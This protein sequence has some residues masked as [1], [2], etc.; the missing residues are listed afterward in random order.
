MLRKRFLEIKNDGYSSIYCVS[1]PYIRPSQKLPE[2]PIMGYIYQNLSMRYFCRIFFYLLTG[3]LL[4]AKTNSSAQSSAKD[5]SMRI[6]AIHNTAREYQRFIATAAPLYSGPQYVEYY[7]LITIGHPFFLNNN[8]NTGSV[9]FDHILYENVKLKYDILENKIVLKDP[10]GLFAV[11]P[12]YDKIDHFTV[13]NHLFSKLE[14]ETINNSLPKSGF[15]E[16]LFTGTNLVLYKKE[17]KI[18]MEDLN[19]KA[20][21]R[22]YI[23]PTINYYLKKGNAYYLFN[24]QKHVLD[25]L[26]DR[27]TELRQYIRKTNP[28]FSNDA[29]N[30][31]LS[32]LNYY[33]SLSK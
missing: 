32:V 19:D 27:K 25:I 16:V 13:E 28:D 31:L 15:Y 30:A 12:D 2:F 26:K 23:V 24:R 20:G 8:F 22:R 11:N 9:R 1:K 29:D 5:S 7:L 14:K 6:A 17:T 4:L 18:L 3:A 21:P 33:E 10:S